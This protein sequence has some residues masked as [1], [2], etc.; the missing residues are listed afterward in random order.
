M[1]CI[2]NIIMLTV[3]ETEYDSSDILRSINFAVA[4]RMSS[5]IRKSVSTSH[6][7]CIKSIVILRSQLTILKTESSKDFS[8]TN[9]PTLI[10]LPYLSIL[11]SNSSSILLSTEAFT[12]LY[13]ASL[14]LF[15][16]DTM[17]SLRRAKSNPTL[18]YSSDERRPTVQSTHF[19]MIILRKP[20]YAIV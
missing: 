5:S 12:F 17:V 13:R 20:A 3:Q 8:S 6:I 11:L 19:R 10:L 9:L 2:I 7:N 4:C 15:G 1:H 14:C 16:M 18:S